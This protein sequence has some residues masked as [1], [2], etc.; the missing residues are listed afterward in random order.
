MAG[1]EQRPRSP[2]KLRDKRPLFFWAEAG[3]CGDRTSLQRR[4]PL[5]DSWGFGE[6]A[7]A[8]GRDMRVGRQA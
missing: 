1:R 3:P 6:V 5:A 7:V 2:A 8:R 4:V